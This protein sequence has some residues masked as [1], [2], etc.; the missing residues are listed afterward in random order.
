MIEYIFAA[1]FDIDKGVCVK[2]CCPFKPKLLDET[3]LASYMIPDGAHKRDFDVT[4]FKIK[5]QNESSQEL[6]NLIRHEFNTRKPLASLYTKK[7][8][9]TPSLKPDG[10]KELFEVTLIENYIH[11]QPQNNQK[12][13]NYPITKIEEYSIVFDSFLSITINQESFGFDFLDNKNAN[14]LEFFISVYNNSINKAS[15]S[16]KQQQQHHDSL[17]KY[18]YFHNVIKTAKSKEFKRGCLIRSIAVC[19]STINLFHHLTDVLIPYLDIFLKMP[20]MLQQ[21][22]LLSLKGVLYTALQVINIKIREYELSKIFFSPIDMSYLGTPENPDQHNALTFRELRQ[23]APL[24]PSLIEFI[25][26][27]KEKTMTIYFHILNGNKVLFISNERSCRAICRIVQACQHLLA[28]LNVSARIFPYESLSNTTFLSIPGYIAGVTN[29][30]FKM[31]TSWW[32]ICCDLGDGSIIDNHAPV[33]S[34]NQESHHY[35]ENKL[36]TIDSEL[37]SEILKRLKESAVNEQQIKEYFY[38]YTKNLIDFSTNSSNMIDYQK[39]DK[40]LLEA[41][42]TRSKI[43]K[44]SCTYELYESSLLKTREILKIVFG[45]K[46]LDV[47]TALNNFSDKKTFSDVELFKDYSVLAENLKDP[48]KLGTFIR[49]LTMKKGDISVL[50]SG[51]FSSN[52][53]VRKKTVE[54]LMIFEKSEYQKTLYSCLNYYI[55]SLYNSQKELYMASQLK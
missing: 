55:I 4:N 31:K 50:T 39:E 22:D 5:L 45:E 46:Y 14:I 15:F 17:E 26:L 24:E 33:S 40:V 48:L 12:P 25:S 43:W 34:V 1:E 28:P 32:D 49:H 42:E 27:F 6:I 29:P 54:F 47:S 41:F 10:A 23:K 3:V 51:L 53:D 11:L 19:S 36:Q 30:I 8:H 2:Y 16:S 38:N 35:V 37:I 20:V 9:W 52:Q 13:L 21:S 18:F 7:N 44:K